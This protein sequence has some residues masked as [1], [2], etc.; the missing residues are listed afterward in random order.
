MKYPKLR[1]HCHYTWE[2]SGTAQ[3]ICKLKYSV[4]K[5]IPIDFYKRSYYDYHFIIKEVAEEF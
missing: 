2:Y 4:P 5:K 1:D 3:S